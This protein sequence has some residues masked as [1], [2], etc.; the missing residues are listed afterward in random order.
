LSSQSSSA[1]SLDTKPEAIH[2]EVEGPP[3]KV[4]IQIRALRRRVQAAQREFDMAIACHE[5]WKPAAYDKALH[6]RLGHSLAANTFIVVRLALRREM[7]LALARVWDHSKDSIGVN[8]L[9]N[10]LGN[11]RVMEALTAE[12]EAHWR[13]QPI[14]GLENPSQEELRVARQIEVEFAQKQ[15]DHL[16]QS[17]DN[18]IA[19]IKNWVTGGT[20]EKLKRLRNQHLAHRQLTPVSIKDGA[21]DASEEE[22]EIF[23]T[24]TSTLIHLLRL[25]ADDTH[26]DPAAT[27]NLYRHNAKLFWAGVRGERT[28][29]HPDYRPPRG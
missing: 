25:A 11:K 12:C 20:Y 5:A 14:L 23:Y 8:R 26:Y 10:F 19:I 9:P 17:A 13:D 3:M 16:Q 15:S 29:G 27:A 4:A 18:A 7:L 22:I 21:I 6:E 28:V 24:D 2:S 1:A